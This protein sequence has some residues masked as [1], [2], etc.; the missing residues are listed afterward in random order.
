M[1]GFL[2]QRTREAEPGQQWAEEVPENNKH[3]RAMLLGTAEQDTW[4]LDRE[5]ARS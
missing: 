1:T 3:R 5:S 2:A 4:C